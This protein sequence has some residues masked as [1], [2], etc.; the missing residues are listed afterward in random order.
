MKPTLLLIAVLLAGCGPELAPEEVLVDDGGAALVTAVPD[1]VGLGGTYTRVGLT[2]LGQLNRMTLRPAG[3]PYAGT[4]SRT[5]N[6]FCFPAPSCATESGSYVASAEN[7]AIGFAHLIFDSSA[8][9]RTVHRIDGITRL[10]G[11]IQTLQLRPLVGNTFGAPFVM[12][13]IAP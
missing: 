5:L 3:T 11:R 9:V 6:R 12:R 2:P 7:P 8:G 1:L 10:G 13:W 4:H